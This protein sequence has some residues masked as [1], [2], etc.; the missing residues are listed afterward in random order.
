MQVAVHALNLSEQLFRRRKWIYCDAPDM[1]F[2]PMLNLPN[3][4]QRLHYFLIGYY[5][6][7][8]LKEMFKVYYNDEN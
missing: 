1:T 5:F 8:S 2:R 7:D 6:Y 3:L 4:H